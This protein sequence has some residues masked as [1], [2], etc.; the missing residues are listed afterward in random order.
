MGQD[1]ANNYVLRGGA[2]GAER[3]RLLA[4]AVWPTT[5]SFLRR[6][7]LRQG[8]HCLDAGCG[9]GAVSLKL[10]G[11]V[12]VSGKVVGIDLDE[13]CLGL[14]RQEGTRRNL[15]PIFRPESVTD[16]ADEGIYDLVYSRFL[17]THLPEP[18]RAI[19]RMVRAARPGG[20]VAVEDIEFSGHFCYPVCPAFDRY[21]CLY[22]QAVRLTGGDPNIGPRL[23]DLLMETGLT[24]IDL[25]VVQPAFRKGRG[26]R[27]AQVTLEHIREAV[28]R[29]QLA[30]SEEIDAVIRELDQF[31]RRR[32]TIISLPRIFQVCG[33]R[34]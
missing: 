3:L 14:A 34:R 27:M 21:L 1:E 2:E 29:S 16:L 7:G 30:T 8:M 28:V 19:E 9:I 10:S 26:K 22:Q 32:R 5:R 25:S 18:W 23:V 15:Q 24:E 13:R 31:A 11:R 6:L 20:L 4:R 33:R 12:G 17:L